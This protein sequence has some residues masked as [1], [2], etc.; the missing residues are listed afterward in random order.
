MR[1]VVIGGTGHIGSYLVEKTRHR[2]TVGEHDWEVDAFHGD[3]PGLV[4]A[5]IELGHEAQTFGRPEWLGEEVSDDPR[6]YSGYLAQEPF[7][8]WVRRSG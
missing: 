5:E 7:S 6:Y 4:L 3:N 1:V 2:V 8:A